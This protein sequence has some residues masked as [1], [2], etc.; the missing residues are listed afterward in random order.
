MLLRMEFLRNG[1][2]KGILKEL[3]NVTKESVLNQRME[4][5]VASVIRT[6]A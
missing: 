1:F 3:R 5:K 2:G 6:Q 4:I